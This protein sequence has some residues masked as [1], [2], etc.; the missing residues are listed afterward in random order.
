MILEKLLSFNAARRCTHLSR[1]MAAFALLAVFCSSASAIPVNHG[2]FVGTSITYQN[3]TEDNTH[4][5]SPKVGA[6]TIDSY[7]TVYG[8][9]TISGDALLFASTNFGVAA[10]GGATDFLDG[11]LTTRMV[12][13][14]GNYIS[15]VQW[16]ER[17]DYTMIGGAGT[18]VQ[19][20][21]P[22]FIRIEETTN[23]PI[24]PIYVNSNVV[25]TPSGGDYFAP[26]EN[27]SGKLWSGNLVQD[28][29]AILALNKIPGHATKVTFS[30]D[31][32]LIA[33]TTGGGTALLKKKQSGSFASLEV[34]PE[35][36]SFLLASLGVA[37]LVGVRLRKR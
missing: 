27:G 31:N 28:I 25:M 8:A 35:P 9:P 1:I 6:P 29:D 10:A 30:I 15:K 24:T 14:A 21:A 18:Y 20:T 37:A 19:V 5:F 7:P 17:G 26:G 33:D 16:T 12:A 13:S 2:N 32:I 3:V 11:T 36:S 22:F 34:V 23:G 4:V